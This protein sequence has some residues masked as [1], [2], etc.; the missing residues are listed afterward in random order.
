ML[1]LGLT[2]YMQ[3]CRQ[4]LDA[5]RAALP[6]ISDANRSAVTAGV[7]ACDASYSQCYRSDPEY[8]ARRQIELTKG[9]LIVGGI[10][11]ASYVGAKKTGSKHPLWW[12]IGVP[13]GFLGIGAW[14]SS[15]MN[16]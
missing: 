6:A 4:K 12:G 2:P 13:L 16:G 9:V 11:L 7:A 10:G 14:L 5:C 8:V 1:G 3:D 15:A